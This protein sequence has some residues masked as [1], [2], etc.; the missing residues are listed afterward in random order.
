MPRA[1]GGLVIRAPHRTERR[2]G[3]RSASASGVDG[4]VDG[5]WMERLRDIS[6][7]SPVEVGEV[8]A[9][10]EE[11]LTPHHARRIRLGSP[12]SGR[13]PGQIRLIGG[14]WTRHM[15]ASPVLA[16]EVDGERSISSSDRGR[17]WPTPHITP[18]TI[19]AA[20]RNLT[21]PSFLS[22]AASIWVFQVCNTWRCSV[23][24]H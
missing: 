19:F 21:S 5:W 16:G 15:Q 9:E 14:G 17:R 6:V 22:T 18:K 8:E 20:I 12:G 3:A 4:A 7:S 24:T 10:A 23:S 13:I 2:C 11:G 1:L